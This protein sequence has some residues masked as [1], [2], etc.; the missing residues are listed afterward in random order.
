MFEEK[1]QSINV[2]LALGLPHGVELS[3]KR[4]DLI[5]P[6]IP[7]NKFRKLK[8]NF[9]AAKEQQAR[10]LI[11]FGGAYSNHISAV[12]EL[13]A[14][15]GFKTIGYIRGEELAAKVASNST[16]MKAKSLGMELRFLS[17]ER[18]REKNETPFLEN[19]KKEVPT[20]YII[21]E[22]GTNE[23]AIRG[24]EE[25]IKAK[26]EIYDYICVAVGTGGTMSGIVR[27]AKPTQCVLGFQ[28]LKGDFLKDEISKWVG[29][30]TNWKMIDTYGFGGY[31]KIK[32]E[33]I[34]FMNTFKAETKIPLDPIYTGKM[35][36]GILDLIE[37]RYFKENSKVLA[38]H[39]G[40]LQGIAGMNVKLKQKG[41][42]LIQ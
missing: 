14:R 21:P 18:Y 12:A 22:G 8:Y 3:V 6:H 7:G 25:I 29:T 35:M 30:R 20:G 16:L 42:P 39:S 36:F 26:D 1:F 13:G 24:C 37:K 38:I 41:W 10:V 5:H 33:L 23:L 2:N 19:L 32:P 11:T 31:A 17:R 40:G 28:A 4:E 34:S 15:S 27:A 9:A